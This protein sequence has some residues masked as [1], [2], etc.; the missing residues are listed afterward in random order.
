M[1]HPGGQFADGGVGVRKILCSVALTVVAVGFGGTDASAA[2]Q[3]VAGQFTVH[4]PKAGQQNNV[5]PC[6]ANVFCGVGNLGGLGAAEIDV[7]D[8]NFEPVPSTNCL[9][10]DKEDDISLVGTGSTLVLVGSGRL[11]F[12][13]NSGN[14]PPSPSNQ[15]YG[16][17][18]LWTS[19]LSVDGADSTG[20][21]A[22]ATGTATE[23]FTVAGGVGIWQVAGTVTL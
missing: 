18:S 21:F 2:T 12:P 23:T 16:H 3:L 4:F 8:S 17:P 14:V 10:F 5:Y 13:G 15:D 9:S 1:S 20:I 6:P 11:C 19:S 7:F 22:G